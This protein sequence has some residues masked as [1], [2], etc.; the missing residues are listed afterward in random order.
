MRVCALRVAAAL[1]RDPWL[2][3]GQAVSSSVRAVSSEAGGSGGVLVQVLLDDTLTVESESV[4][5]GPC[6]LLEQSLLVEALPNTLAFER[7]RVN[8]LIKFGP[9]LSSRAAPP[10]DVLIVLRHTLGLLHVPFSPIWPAAGKVFA[11]ATAAYPKTAWAVFGHA[12]RAVTLGRPPGL[13]DTATS[14]DSSE[15]AQGG[16]SSS[17]RAISAPPLALSRSG[18]RAAQLASRLTSLRRSL[19]SVRTVS[20]AAESAA[21]SGGVG[22]DAAHEHGYLFGDVLA[23]GLVGAATA[24]PRRLLQLISEANSSAAASKG[25]SALHVN[26]HWPLQ[27]GAG[28][29]ADVETVHRHLLD[30]LQAQ[31][32]FAE[33][34]S[35]ALVPLFLCFVKDAFSAQPTAA[36]DGSTTAVS[37]AA[38]P[39]TDVDAVELALPEALERLLRRHHSSVA[40]AAAAQLRKAA[41]RLRLRR[42]LLRAWPQLLSRRPPPRLRRSGTRWPAST[43]CWSCSSW[44]RSGGG[45]ARTARHLRLYRA[46]REQTHSR[47]YSLHELPPF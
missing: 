10:L 23:R 1:P 14:A 29:A 27:L 36:A 7:P 32:A 4:F 17:R 41:R 3:P 33:T 11:V 20:G 16:G 12:L 34:R 40:A 13:E 2:R 6:L 30:I 31:P 28:G 39:D 8:A 19:E 21:G 5:E 47:R 9:A 15:E 18:A 42:L 38:P 25:I 46:I 22:A 35:K 45:P 37:V 26:D 43:R 44:R 24:L